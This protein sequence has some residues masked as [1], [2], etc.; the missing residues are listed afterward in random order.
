MLLQV[1]QGL[2]ES[3]LIERDMPPQPIAC[4][5]NSVVLL[6]QNSFCSLWCAK[7]WG[8]H[9]I[10]AASPTCTWFRTPGPP[11][12]QCVI[13]KGWDWLEHFIICLTDFAP[14]RSLSSD[15]LSSFWSSSFLWSSFF[16]S[17][18][19]FSSF[20]TSCRKLESILLWTTHKYSHSWLV[21]HFY[22]CSWIYATHPDS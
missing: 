7:V 1:Q 13:L 4:L 18:L 21:N 14:A 8:V 6:V 5:A 9:D 10:P 3:C 16:A 11:I 22:N 12:F 17:F 19:H 2:V 15:F 20:F